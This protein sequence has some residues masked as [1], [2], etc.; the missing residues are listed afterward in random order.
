[1]IHLGVIVKRMKGWM[2]YMVIDGITL[3][4][5]TREHLV[6]QVEL[7]YANVDEVLS[8]ISNHGVIKEE[9]T[10]DN[11][12]SGKDWNIMQSSFV[13]TAYHDGIVFQYM[14]IP[15]DDGIIGHAHMR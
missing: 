8:I 12:C 14:I 6:K 11:L 3:T 10:L 4:D 2:I 7:D 9:R 13:V 1:M 15:D 5:K